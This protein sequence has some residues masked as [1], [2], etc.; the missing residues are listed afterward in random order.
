MFMDIKILKRP[1]KVELTH[2]ISNDY[3]NIK[4]SDAQSIR[5]PA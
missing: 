3:G 4:E 1:R 2:Y 5:T